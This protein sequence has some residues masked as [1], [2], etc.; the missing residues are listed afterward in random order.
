M[1]CIACIFD[2]GRRCEV[3]LLIDGEVSYAR[4][5]DDFNQAEAQAARWQRVF[6]DEISGTPAI[7]HRR[8]IQ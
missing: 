6:V 7:T 3:R 4:L 5:C 8:R 2:D 1:R